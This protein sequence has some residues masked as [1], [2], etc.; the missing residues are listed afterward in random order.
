M[1]LIKYDPFREMQ[2]IRNQMNQ[3]L[4]SFGEPVDWWDGKTF[5]PT[6]DVE[7][8]DNEIVVKMDVPGINEKEISLTLSG[9]NLIIQGER[10]SETEDKKK[11]FHRME[12]FYGTFERMIPLPLTVERDKINAEY[13]K[14]VLEVHLP[15]IP[16]VKPKEIPIK[17]K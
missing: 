10:K 12:R 17:I 14:G 5:S 3:W 11:H 8:T 1:R 6:C 4:G 9:D 15:K 7:E 16:E 13:Q 2:G